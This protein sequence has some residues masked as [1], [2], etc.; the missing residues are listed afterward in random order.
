MSN[1]TVIIAKNYLKNAI[2]RLEMK[3]MALKVK[4]VLE[5]QL[6]RRK[7]EPPFMIEIV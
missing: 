7:L 2:K 3:Q 4:G 1:T 5:P 6:F